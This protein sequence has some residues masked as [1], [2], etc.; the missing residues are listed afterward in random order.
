MLFIIIIAS[1]ITLQVGYPFQISKEPD[2]MIGSC[3]LYLQSLCYMVWSIKNI[4]ETFQIKTVSNN[5]KNQS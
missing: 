1:F 2:I 4:V 5:I 3:F